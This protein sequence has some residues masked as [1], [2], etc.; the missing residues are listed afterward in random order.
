VETAPALAS[1]SRLAR[2]ATD[3][4]HPRHRWH[5]LTVLMVGV[6]SSA[7]PTTL[8]SASLPDIAADLDTS[9][10][11]IT[12]VQTAP[13]IVFAVGMPFFGKLGDLHGH[14]RAFIFGFLSVAASA[15]LTAVAWNAGSLIGFRCIGQLA[16]SATSTAAFG[17]IAS[18]FERE[19]RVK[20]IGLYTSVLAISPVIAV[21][22]G[23]P[24]IDAVGWRLLFVMQFV[25]ATLAVLAALP[26]LP[27]TPRHPAA[28]FDIA[29]ASTMGIGI[30]AV[31]FAINRGSPWGWDS[32]AVIAGFVLGPAALAL[33]V[34]VE[35]SR[36]E[37]LLPLEF[38]QDRNFT[39]ALLTNAVLQLSYIGGFAIAPFMVHRL[40][41]YNTY[42]T[43]MVIAVRPVLFSV[44]AWLAGRHSERVDNRQAQVIGSVLLTAGSLVTAWGAAEVSLTLIIVGLAVVGLGG[45]F[46]RPANVT[47]I[48]NSVPQDDVGIAT[49]VLNLTG[50]IGSAVGITVLL[51]MVG[52]SIDPS[53]FAAASLVAT[54]VASLSIATAL[55][56]RPASRHPSM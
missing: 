30:T 31:L 11:V 10:S 18:V 34:V 19:D 21:V 25:P 45:G 50:Q 42:R 46:G 48:T 2:W 47:S 52:E 33:F 37:P 23:G 15:L 12:W 43:S 16:G 14:R 28:R 41:G 22:A 8:L 27:E 5:V 49:G 39:A 7:F 55:L 36:A 1:E 29:G 13:A 51:A 54:A 26:I 3:I 9:T 32:P 53:S 44:G 6:F 35:R 4:D 20:A 40:F 56:L 24:L 17:L 38:F